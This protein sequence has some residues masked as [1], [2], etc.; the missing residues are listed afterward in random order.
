MSGSFDLGDFN[1]GRNYNEPYEY[2]D[3]EDDERDAAWEEYM[4][5]GIDPT[6]GELGPDFDPETG[7]PL[8]EGEVD[9]E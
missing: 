7:E 1:T 5:T 4:S 3:L 9:D 2:Q 8:E 6:G